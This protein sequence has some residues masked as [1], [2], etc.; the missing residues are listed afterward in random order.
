MS[1]I[2]VVRFCLAFG[3]ICISVWVPWY[4]GAWISGIYRWLPEGSSFEYWL[5][6]VLIM[7]I[8][9]VTGALVV[10]PL[11]QLGMW[12]WKGHCE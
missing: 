8:L 1:K 2:R 3:G 5:I 7:L 6:G 4:V 12:I 11:R 9:I 10:P